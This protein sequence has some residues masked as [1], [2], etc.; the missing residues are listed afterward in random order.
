MSWKRFLHNFAEIL[1]AVLLVLL[2]LF[3]IT[4]LSDLEWNAMLDRIGYLE[5]F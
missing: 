4:L 5:V 1:G 2:T 3:Q